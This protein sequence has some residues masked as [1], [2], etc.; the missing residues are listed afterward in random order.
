MSEFWASPE[1]ATWLG[2]IPVPAMILGP[3][4]SAVAV[5]PR[6]AATL[7]VTAEGNTWVDVVEPPFRSMVRARLRLAA[8]AREP[9]SVDCPV[10]GPD[11]GR[12]SRW[13]WHPAPPQN[14][15]VCVGVISP[16]AADQPEQVNKLAESDV[17]ISPQL[18]TA[19]VA[20]LYEAGLALDSAAGMLEGP[21]A[22]A[23]VSAA[24]NI[25]ELVRRIR[26]VVF[27]APANLADGPQKPTDQPHD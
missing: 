5:N 16:D 1:H 20:R 2:W 24:A 11:G 18:A 6:W 21:L 17:R 15:L 19:V 25:D 12:W 13:W 7:R 27:Q 23:L 26:N 22:T 4:G 3:D 9:G 14:L 10:S 8:A